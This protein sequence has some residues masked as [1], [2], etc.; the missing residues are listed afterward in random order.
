MNKFTRSAAALLSAAAMSVS[1]MASSIPLTSN[2]T[3]FAVDTNNDDWLHC[4][5]SRI[6]DMNGNEVWLTGANWFGLNC[7]EAVPHYLWSAD[8]D[9]VLK[10]I[11]D[12]G[13]NIIRFPISTEL[14]L[15]WMNGK[16]NP[17]ESFSANNDPAYT[18]NA[19][20][21]NADGSKK[22]SMEIFDILMRK[23]KKYGIK[24]FI[25]IH[26]PHTDNSGHNYNL[27]YGMK[28]KTCGVVTTEDWIESL[29]WLAEK[30]KND[31]TLLAYDL[32]NEP[33]GKGPEGTAAAKWDGSTDENNW[34][35]AATKCADAILDVNPH[36]LILIEGV[37]QSMS[38]AMDGDYWG[39]PD[40]RDNSPYIGAWWGGNF[41]GAREYPIKPEHGTSQIVYSP[42]DYGPSVYAQT[43]FD[44]DFSE[45]T[46]LD[47]YWYDTWAYINA[48][49]I[50]PELIG[51]WGGHMDGAENQ[52]WMTLLRDYMIKHHINHTFWCLNTNSGDTGGLWDDLGFQAGTGTTIKWNEP[53]YKLFEEALWQTKSGKYIGLDHQVALGANGISLNDFYSKYASSEGSNLDGGKTSSGQP[54]SGDPVKTVKCEICGKDTPASE[55]INSPLGVKLCK[56]CSAAGYG[57]TTTS[58]T[59][60][61]TTT[62]TTSQTTTT[63]TQP[64]VA[65]GKC[66]ECGYFGP[67]SQFE[68][69]EDGK[70][71]CKNGAHKG[72][73]TTTSSTTTSTSTTTITSSTTETTI[74]T[75]TAIGGGEVKSIDTYPTKTKYAKGEKL[76]LSGLS[77]TY[78]Y[79]IY[80]EGIGYGRT[81]GRT[82]VYNYKDTD[83]LNVT[84]ISKIPEVET[85]YSDKNFSEIPEG[86]YTVV[87]S[88]SI[89]G[90]IPGS[91]QLHDVKY[92]ITIGNDSEEPSVTLI[93]DANC[94]GIINIA[95][96]VMIMQALANPSKYGLK[97][98][99]PT[100]ITL[101]GWAN[102]DCAG[103]ND[104]VTN[105]D[106]LAIQKLLLKLIPSLP[107]E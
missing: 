69:H 99:D 5:G 26:S 75:W 102:A 92:D 9:D 11:A 4:E 25:D 62:T 27:W 86:E 81:E 59:T 22:N 67:I 16:P 40:R 54:V 20:C 107:E 60:S 87:L 65:D 19:D 36:A 42:H 33:H 71:Y 104:G 77:L 41:R 101:Q 52:K 32:K 73:V 1:V 14:I 58:R 50:A 21:V 8:M 55:I 7:N 43:W 31:D 28:G 97:G 90:V 34:A 35:Y 23:C 61:S 66:A 74:R 80:Y 48:E 15:S 82:G 17:V 79:T 45:K 39:M 94:D 3:A 83:Q 76:D 56:E 57:G 64:I 53:K 29:V 91:I 12:R 95:D 105:L 72:S 85:T 18:I 6:Y 44:K 24:A 13:I 10:Q 106:A 70:W 37:E 98:D 88:G 30:Y 2:L 46:L 51:E 93:G 47:D 63:T 68:Q 89:Y 38:G 84:V 49:D 78:Q 103:G 96:T 100:H